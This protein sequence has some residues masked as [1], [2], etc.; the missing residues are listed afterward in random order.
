MLLMVFTQSSA[1][2]QSA[3]LSSD[4]Q[5]R[6]TQA[7]F[8]V[9]VNVSDSKPRPI[10]LQLQWNVSPLVD[11]KRSIVNI[12]VDGQIRSTR[13]V[14]D[15]AKGIWR[16]NLRPLPPGKHELSLQI[17][18]RGTDEDCI[19]LPEA[20]WLTL[21]ETST[22]NGASRHSQ[23][24]A[25]SPLAVRD[26][27]S[28][29]RSSSLLGDIKLESAKGS[30]EVVHD[31]AWNA[32]MVSAWLQAHH[33]LANRGLQTPLSQ[34]SAPKS[35]DIAIESPK[36]SLRSFD[37]LKADHP[38]VKRW[39][40]VKDTVYV[41]YA[42]NRSQLELIAKT[43]ENL[44]LG[45]D[46]LEDDERRQVCHQNLCSRSSA[47]AP[48]R[49]AQE[50]SAL[51]EGKSSLWRMATGDQPRGW[52]AQ[53]VGQ[54]RLRQVWVRPVALELQ[55]DVQLHLAA[56]VSQAEQIDPQQS[57]ISVRINDQPIATYSL[58]NWKGGHTKMRIPQSL[59]R[60]NA[61]VMDFEVRL[62]PRNLQRCSYLAQE[63]YWV[64]LDPETQLEAT[65]K[66]EAA[67][68]IAGF[69]QRAM[70][71]S[72]VSVTWNELGGQ[73]PAPQLLAHFSPM[74]Q[75]FHAASPARATSRLAF[76]NP[77]SCK[78]SACVVLHAADAAGTSSSGVLT[79]QKALSRVPDQAKGMPDL[80]A[81]GTAV[82]AWMPDQKD[83]SEQLHV[84]VG[85]TK[86]A[87]IPSPALPTFAGAIAIHTDQW[88][89]FADET[90]YQTSLS[91][92]V[93]DT[94]GNVSQQ[95]GRLRWVNLIWALASL[96]IIAGFALLYWR[97]KRT[98]NPKTWEVQ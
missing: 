54:H 34:A 13:R 14:A 64:A 49:L 84:V 33:F 41:L 79:W 73:L 37:Q 74:L 23:T 82:I 66:H 35:N 48:K 83:Q 97:K 65:F 38:A 22:I 25:N 9:P 69:W 39:N 72:Q 75:S 98:A 87:P 21:L 42:P 26:F 17:H 51:K 71:R 43:P 67:P 12:L 28:N 30:V 1:F 27:P 76:V 36:L 44:Q 52:T 59:W 62:V 85:M 70:E 80:S 63:D 40:D 50:A 11:P 81:Q 94:G 78:A 55:S 32:S 68:G 4:V 88:Q 18:L 24:S 89:F 16:I 6:G 15:I 86:D 96:L 90:A 47:D 5:L 57:S 8:D 93:A 58:A 95:Q 29:W 91:N 20:L 7:R 53:G 31:F 19:P 10:E 92:G 2:S 45:L 46:L 3:F 61:W 77:N 60:A 56:R